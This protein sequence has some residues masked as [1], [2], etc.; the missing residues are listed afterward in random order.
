M[1]ENWETSTAVP[2]FNESDVKTFRLP[3]K[4][5]FAPQPVMIMGIINSSNDNIMFTVERNDTTVD[6]ILIVSEIHYDQH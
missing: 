2:S 1:Q 3:N 6:T 5:T 4:V